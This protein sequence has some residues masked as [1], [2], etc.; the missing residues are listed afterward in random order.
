MISVA[1]V[2]GK[3]DLRE[4]IDLPYRLYRSDPLWVAPIRSTQRDLFDRSGGHPF[5]EHSEVAHFLARD[6]IGVVVGRITATINHRHNEYHRDRIGFFGFLEA[7]RDQRVFDALFDRASEWLRS[8]GMEAIRGPLNYS[9]N[10][11][12]GLLVEGFDSSPMLMMPYNP[13]YYAEGIEAAGFSKAKDL[14]A[15]RL[16]AEGLKWDRMRKVAALVSR[17]TGT[18]IRDIR[19][20]RLYEEVLILMDVY[21]ECWNRNWGFVPMTDAEFR[22]MA[23]DLGMLLEPALAPMI[24]KGD[25]AVAFAVALPDANQALLKARGSLLGALVALKAPVLRTRIDRFRVLLLGVREK[26][27]GCGLES[28]LIARLVENG[29]RLG[30]RWAELSWVLEDNTARRRILEREMDAMPYKTYRV[31]EKSLRAPCGSVG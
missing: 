12:S 18:E 24:F 10:E 11:E 23:K 4:F 26:W 6:R 20:D 7:A 30:Y 16:E 2:A 21:N 31:Y 14:L 28:L 1:E 19:K 15:Y 3:K 22:Q 27:R 9:T 17:R 25:A 13:P 5:H 8:K 29:I